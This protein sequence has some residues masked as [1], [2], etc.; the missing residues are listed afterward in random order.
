MPSWLRTGSR[1]RALMR[2]PGM[3]QVVGIAVLVIVAEV[4]AVGILTGAFSSQGRDGPAQGGPRLARLTEANPHAAP[5]HAEG[6]AALTV[7]GRRAPHAPAVQPVSSAPAST[8]VVAA[9]AQH[10]THRDAP[11]PH[12]PTRRAPAFI[13]VHQHR[14]RRVPA[15]N[16]DPSTQPQQGRDGGEHHQGDGGGDQHQGDAGG[17]QDDAGDNR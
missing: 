5:Q 10:V 8:P 6:K 17:G 16:V 4:V 3:L 2:T 9:P 15:P 11:A 13:H 1:L 14:D 7:A 12:A